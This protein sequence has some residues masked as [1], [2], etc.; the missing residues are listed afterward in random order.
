MTTRCII[1][2]DSPTDAYLAQKIAVELF[3]EVLVVA[4]SADL[5]KHIG[6]FRPDIVFMDV[7]LGWE[8]GLSLIQEVRHRDDESSIVPFVVLSS[9]DSAEDIE[10]AK[11]QGAGA[12]VIK[13][14]TRDRMEAAVRGLF[15]GWA[16]PS[17]VPGKNVS[18][19]YVRPT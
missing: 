5:L 10:W 15:L 4:K 14:A 13:P 3:D 11:Q 2:D 19:F 12:Y 6:S 8:N 16:G 18:E 17:G 1:V 9:K 7:M